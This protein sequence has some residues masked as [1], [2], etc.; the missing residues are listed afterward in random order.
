MESVYS[1][2][3]CGRGTTT[4]SLSSTTLTPMQSSVS[5]TT[6][7]VTTA[8]NNQC[9]NFI[10]TLGAK[11]TQ[12][13]LEVDQALKNDPTYTGHR[14]KG[15][16]LAWEYERADV[17][18]G[19]N[20]SE[21]WSEAEKN[22]MR[23]RKTGTVRNAEGHHRRNVADHPED[24]ADPDNI[25]FYRSREEHLKEGHDG[26]FQ[27]ESDQP[28]MDKEEML[29]KTN[30]RRVVRNELKGIGLAAL[31]GFATGASIGF[32]VSLAQN[33]ISPDT[34]MQAFKD[35]GVAGLEG[36]ALSVVSYGISRM[37]GGLV[38][39]ALTGA[40]TKLGVEITE[41]ITK[42]CNMGGVGAI[43]I[44]TTSIYTYIKL[45]GQGFN[46]KDA[47][48]T[49]GKQALISVSSLAVTVIVQSVY[50][51]PA[52]IAVGIGISAVMLGY[53]MYNVYH[54]K[55][56]ADKIQLYSINKVYSSLK[57]EI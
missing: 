8:Y 38:T 25:K 36:A 43:L 1:D 16:S 50:G 24:Q 21:N 41:N 37:V 47:L 18:M 35:G 22:D 45:R 33:G 10:K 20:G 30:R 11:K 55:Q 34:L 17:E 57:Y 56:L 52:A 3:L 54:N 5:Y 7:F 31:I 51:G 40:L 29:K 4:L 44:L 46:N 32:I 28:K 23:T 42:A 2:Q 26:N 9:D 48:K 39:S 12:Y 14:D 6:R 15:V 49:V 53:S 27:N 13:Q 19:G